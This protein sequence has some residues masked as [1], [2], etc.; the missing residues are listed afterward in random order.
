LFRKFVEAAGAK[1]I[2]GRAFV[3]VD[4]TRS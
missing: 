4:E 1:N 2:N 3:G